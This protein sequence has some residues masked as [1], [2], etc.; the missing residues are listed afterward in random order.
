MNVLLSMGN[1]VLSGFNWLGGW[2]PQLAIRAL[3]AYE[4]WQSGITKLHASNW[5][6]EIKGDFPFPFNLIPADISWFIAMWSELAG[7]VAMLI[8]L[9]TRFASAALMF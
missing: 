1:T 8:G 5:F 7:S 3:L 2:F 6:G 4:F 9:A